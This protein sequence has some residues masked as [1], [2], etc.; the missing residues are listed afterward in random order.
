LELVQN[1]KLISELWQVASGV[2]TNLPAALLA[3]LAYRLQHIH[4]SDITLHTVRSAE[5][6]TAI[7]ENVQG[8]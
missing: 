4:P 7:Y 2:E 8:R 5:N 3:K 6:L 1:P